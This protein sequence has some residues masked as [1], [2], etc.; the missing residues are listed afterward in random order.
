MITPCLNY[1]GDCEAARYR[2]RRYIAESSRPRNNR[3]RDVSPPRRTIQSLTGP[4]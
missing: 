3:S 4:G 2:H 1:S